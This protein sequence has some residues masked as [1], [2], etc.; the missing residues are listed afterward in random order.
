MERTITVKGLGKV[1]ASPDLITISFDLE[2]TEPKYEQTMETSGRLLAALRAS[3]SQTGLDGKDLKTTGFSVDTKY[4]SYRDKNNNYQQRF[5]GYTCVHRLSLEFALDMKTLASVLSAIA[6]CE[7]H[8]EFK[9]RFTVKDPAAVSEQL[10]AKAIKDAAKKAETLAKAANV[11]LG[12]VQRIDC[13]WEEIHLYSETDMDMKC[14]APM[15]A[16]SS[17]PGIDIEPDDIDVSDSVIV[18]WTI[19]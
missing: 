5:I 14:C 8:P 12:A 13:N 4:E 2:I 15:L 19:E 6:E 9:I 18:V 10:L 3:I 17:A 11:K 1:S 16:E 7:A